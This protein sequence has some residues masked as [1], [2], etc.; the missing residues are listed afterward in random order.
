MCEDRLLC[1][2][3]RWNSALITQMTFIARG[4]AASPQFVG[5]YMSHW[6]D[7]ERPLPSKAGFTPLRVDWIL[8]R[9]RTSVRNG[10]AVLC[11]LPRLDLRSHKPDPET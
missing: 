2:T 4:V 10:C 3:R 6:S 7:T 5:D 11:A 9:P 1:G 8:A